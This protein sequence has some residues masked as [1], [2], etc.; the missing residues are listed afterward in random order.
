MTIYLDNSATT[1]V[2][3]E[4]LTAM[5]P[6]LTERWG[7]PS[8]IH[9]PGREARNA[10]EH[11]RAQVAALVGA[12]PSEI[13][14][15]PAGTYSNNTAILGR[16]R[17]VEER[18]KGRHLITCAIEHSSSWLPAL[19]LKRQQWD[20]TILK[21]NE[22]GIIDLDAL[23][24]AIRPETSIISLMWANNEIGSL[25]PVERVAEI[26][27][28]RGIFFHCDAIQI[29]GKLPIDVT[30]FGADTLS[31][32]GHKF[33]AP[34]GVGALYIREGVR[35]APLVFGGGQENGYFPGTES[36]ANIVAMGKAAELVAAELETNAAHLRE[37]QRLLTGRLTRYGSVRQTGPTDPSNRLPG[38]VSL[39]VTGASGADLVTQASARGVFISSV[40]ACASGESGPSRVLKNVGVDDDDALGA[41]RIVAGNTNTVEECKKAA[42]VIGELI[43]TSAISSRAHHGSPVLP[44]LFQQTVVS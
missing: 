43:A 5:L 15:T 11:A 26:A 23:E 1:K 2:R 16:A 32:S 19:S 10:V 33:Y 34:K 40:S 30:T 31:L 25:Q 27:R 29:P 13:Y 17:Y 22:E 12:R 28:E 36:L 3:D 37:C 39:V 7:N 4:V 44:N 14:F 42:D 38:H 6:Y 8:S 9:V 35:V 24:R 41:L 21:V 18:N 20:V